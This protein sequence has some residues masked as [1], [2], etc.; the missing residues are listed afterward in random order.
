MTNET[1]K[2]ENKQ[3]QGGLIDPVVMRFEAPKGERVH[4][5]FWAVTLT[6]PTGDNLWWNST[7]KKWEPYRNNPSHGYS[8]HAPCRTLKA[9]NRMLC[10][11]PKIKGRCV[12]VNKYT[13]YDVY[14]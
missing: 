4:R 11:Y 5:Y 14:A 9:F 2:T 10:K 1:E 3:E 12:L 7:L 8:T 13:G 6:E